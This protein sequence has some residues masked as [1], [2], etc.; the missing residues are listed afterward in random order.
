MFLFG[1]TSSLYSFS[2]D[3]KP[4]SD[5]R[6][7]FEVA[8]PVPIMT[9]TEEPLLY[10]SE[11]LSLFGLV[12]NISPSDDGRFIVTMSNR[13][14]N[15]KPFCKSELSSSCRVTVNNNSKGNF[16]AILKISANDLSPG[17]LKIKK[18]SLLRIYGKLL[19]HEVEGGEHKCEKNS[20]GS[21]IVEGQFY[22]HWPR[23]YFVSI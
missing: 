22:R 13:V 17:P 19:C 18:G 6:N 12:E 3:Y 21:I 9:L 15:K 5:E 11:N 2:K 10:K 8:T 7:F 14:V 23:R 4:L 1:C 16:S 20:D